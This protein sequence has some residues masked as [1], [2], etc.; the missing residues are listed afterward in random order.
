MNSTPDMHSFYDSGWPEWYDMKEYGPASK[1]VRRIIFQLLSSIE[2][3]SVMDAGCGVAT[4]LD[5]IS[6]SYPQ[7]ELYGCE[8]SGDAVE[9]AKKRMPKG[10]FWQID[11]SKDAAPA[12]VDLVTCIDVLEHI[13]DDLTAMRN[14][15][16]MTRKYVLIV[17]PIGPLFE[18]ERVRV[19]HVHGYSQAEFDG[20]LLASGLKI[21]KRILWGFPMYSLYRRLLHLLPEKTVT[22]KFSPFKKFTSYVLYLV[23]YLSLPFWGDRYFLVCEKVNG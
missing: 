22:G 7:A 16:K 12:Q 15:A 19:G 10:H 17:V 18:A 1:H 5:D 11:L 20:K 2:F 3:N 21:K 23:L 14:L 8:Y 6:R 9:I 13:D 4:L